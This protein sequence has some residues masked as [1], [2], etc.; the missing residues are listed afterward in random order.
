[1][2][3]VK[4][5]LSMEPGRVRVGWKCVSIAGGDQ[6]VVLAG[7]AGKLRWSAGVLASTQTQQ[8][9]LSSLS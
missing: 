8:V 5:D 2:S 7:T 1:M 3:M 6:C 4:Y 9:S